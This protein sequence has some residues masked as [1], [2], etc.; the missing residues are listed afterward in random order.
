MGLGSRLRRGIRRG[1]VPG[2]VSQ[3]RGSSN[4]RV[5]L[6]PLLSFLL[7]PFSVSFRHYLMRN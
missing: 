7:L 4:V 3:Y 6:L 2:R 1:K 5:V